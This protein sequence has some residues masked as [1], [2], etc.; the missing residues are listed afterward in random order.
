MSKVKKCISIDEKTVGRVARIASAKGLPDSEIYE[1]LLS[2]GLARNGELTAVERFHYQRQNIIRAIDSVL[3]TFGII[4]EGSITD[5]FRCVLISTFG[6]SRCKKRQ[7]RDEIRESSVFEALNLIKD[8]DKNLF[9]ELLTDMS[10]FGE[11]RNRYLQKY[12]KNVIPVK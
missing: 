6:L 1:T 3:L 8:M 9:D 2:I 12:P 4:Q 10:K 11:I 7:I 5:K